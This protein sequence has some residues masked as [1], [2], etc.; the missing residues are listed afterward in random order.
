VTVSLTGALLGLTTIIVGVLAMA[1]FQG[2]TA[3]AYALFRQPIADDPRPAAG[4]PDLIAALA[5]TQTLSPGSTPTFISLEHPTERGQAIMVNASQ[6]NRLVSGDTFYFDG[7]GRLLDASKTGKTNLGE[8]IIGSLGP[9]HFGWY[10][11]LAIKI[12]YF[13]LGLALTSV[14]SSGVAIWLARK[15][16]KGRPA[17]RWERLWTATVWSQPVAFAASALVSVAFAAATEITPLLIWAGVTLTL[18][19]LGI[20]VTPKRLSVVL[21]L[22]ASGLILAAVAAHLVRHGAHYADP[23]AWTVN[24]ALVLAA[25]ILAGSVLPDPAKGETRAPTAGPRE[26]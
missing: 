3:K 14:T 6:P 25:L 8:K 24:L 17:P 1:M 4:L 26:A 9:L 15:R 10:G 22:V 12:A 5:S 18:I 11:G 23:A 21:R 13:L 7:R 20:L 19:S 2:D 16:D